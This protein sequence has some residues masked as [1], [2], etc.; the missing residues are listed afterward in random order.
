MQKLLVIMPIVE[1]H[2]CMQMEFVNCRYSQRV[3]LDNTTYNTVMYKSSDVTY[4][5]EHTICSS[6]QYPRL[7]LIQVYI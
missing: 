4:P 7:Q 6:A 3:K 5:Q 1:W 2:A